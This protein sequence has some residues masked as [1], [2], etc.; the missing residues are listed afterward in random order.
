MPSELLRLPVTE[1]V[2]VFAIAMLVFVAVPL[3][4]E[5]LHVPG[6]I[7]LIIAGA[8]LGPNA[9]GVLERDETIVLLGTVG[10]LYL[11]FMAGVEID[12][13]GF[14][15]YRNRS[16]TFGAITFL[17]PQVVG[18]GIGLLLGYGWAASLLLAS[19]F[20][21]H[22]LLAYPIASR[23]G[24][25]KNA[26]VTTTVGGT[27]VTDSAAL[28]V[29]AIIAASV[30]G[31]LNAAFWIRLV[32]SLVVFVAVVMLGVPRLGRWFFRRHGSEGAAE[33]VFVLAALFVCAVL[34]EFAGVEPIIGAFLAGLAINRLIPE[35]GPLSNRLH[36][37]GNAF[38]IPFFLFSVGMLVN[39]RVLAGGTR[40]WT[41]ML[42]MSG[43]VI[44]TKW[45]AARL[46]QRLFGYSPEEGWT[47]F[48]LSVP[49]AAATLAAALIGYQ[50]RLF[51]ETVL[52]GTILMI[53]V[54]CTLGPWVVERYGRKLALLEERKPYE[55]SEAPQRILLAI[56][57]PAT[58]E[59]LTEFALLIRDPEVGEPLYP[60]IVVPGRGEDDDTA[61][62]VA[63]AEKMLS[64]SV[65]YAAG[66]D[67]PVA[68]LTR[69]DH[70]F[71]NGITR[72]ITETRSNTVV[73]GWDRRQSRRFALAGRVLD[74]VV[75]RT[76]QL[77]L[78]TKVGGALNTIGRIIVV[79]PPCSDR[80]VGFCEAVRTIKILASRL[81]AKLTGLVVEGNCTDYG[82]LFEGVKPS[83]PTEFETLGGWETLLPRLQEMVRN[84]DLIVVL[85]ARR[86]SIAWHREIERLP[87]QLDQF[88][89]GCFVVAYPS[90]AEEPQRGLQI[91]VEQMHP[92]A[93]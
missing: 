54:T 86:G 85:G 30:E 91:R 83:V 78:V 31:E 57:N 51:D 59:S 90:E 53:L 21:S 71:A 73:V 8:V 28:L 72:A 43:T 2:M 75:E 61:P 29:L 62:Q 15:K 89:D 3:V 7:G 14:R 19:V 87:G 93:V 79:L 17:L 63:T 76:Q 6:M 92:A 37:F 56:S 11:M 46:S 65:L 34:A 60:L 41:V 80:S 24:L 67:T 12:L 22:T 10:L 74:Q 70:N 44:V 33:Y 49:Q 5:R 81:G 32:V 25:A 20:A 47:M 52:N 13:H 64:R 69:V 26:A 39:V 27:I 1:P 68:P 23:F 35:H 36:L 4:F 16:L 9:L 66:A 48:G 38:F 18:T 42:A 45:M 77:V 58:A 40:A 50:I 55:P 88:I 82:A 84:D